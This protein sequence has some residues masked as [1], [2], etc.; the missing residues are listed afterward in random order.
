M[1]ILRVLSAR[2]DSLVT[3]DTEKVEEGNLEARAAVEEAER[4]FERERARGST[5]F[6][7]EAGKPAERIEKFDQ[8]AEQTVIVPMIAGG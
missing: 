8:T 4:V 7:V 1:C 2:G 3:W 5:A 6:R